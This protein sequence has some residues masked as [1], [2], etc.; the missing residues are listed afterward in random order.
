MKKISFYIFLFFSLNSFGQSEPATLSPKAKALCAT[1]MLT[2][3]ELFSNPLPPNET[4]K[5]DVFMLMESA[6]YRLVYNG[7]PEAGTWSLDKAGLTLTLTSDQGAVKKIKIIEAS[8]SIIKVDYQD[9]DLVHNI[10]YYASNAA[11]K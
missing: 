1:W 7:A 3:T 11:S 8:S 6:R 10:L 9:A 4:Q 2:Q 5:N